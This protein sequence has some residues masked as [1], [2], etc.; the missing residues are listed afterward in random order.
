MLDLLVQY[1]IVFAIIAAIGA[2]TAFWVL[3]SRRHVE[4]PRVEIGS[5]SSPTLTRTVVKSSD[6]AATSREAPLPFD[7][8]TSPDVIPDDLLQIKGVGP[9]LARMLMDMGIVYFRQIAAWSPEDV[10]AV[11]TR[12]GPFAG[13]VARDNWVEQARMLDAG[14]M[15]AFRARFGAL[16]ETIR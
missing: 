14:D 13:R 16:G 2:G 10:A 7:V 12:L 9:R 4:L 6:W 11:D 1:W 3:S 5:N 15:D 8:Y